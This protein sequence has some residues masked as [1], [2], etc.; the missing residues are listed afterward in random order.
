MIEPHMIL[1]IL[2]LQ[3]T[4]ERPTGPKDEDAFYQ[5]YAEPFYLRLYQGWVRLYAAYRGRRPSCKDVQVA[6]SLVPKLEA[7]N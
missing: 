5:Q 3:K 2:S 1:A 4:C 6:R 7:C